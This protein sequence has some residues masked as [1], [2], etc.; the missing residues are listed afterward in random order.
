MGNGFALPPPGVCGMPVIAKAEKS[1]GRL[2][3]DAGAS[4]LIIDGLTGTGGGLMG[5]IRSGLSLACIR[6]ACRD[7]LLLTDALLPEREWLVG[8]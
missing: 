8:P 7:V 1:L 4:G 3:Y 6:S 5:D 2:V